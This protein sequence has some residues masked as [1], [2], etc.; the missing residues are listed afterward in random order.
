MIVGAL[1]LF[2]I[3][4]PAAG[5]LA[6]VAMVEGFGRGP[7]FSGALVQCVMVFYGLAVALI[8]VNVS[9]TCADVSKII[10]REAPAR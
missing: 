7:E 9:Q 8:A 6:G 1:C 2:R 10:S 4:R 5:A 3:G